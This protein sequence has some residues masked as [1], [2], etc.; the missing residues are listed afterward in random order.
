MHYQ[1]TTK[2]SLLY[3]VIWI[4]GSKASS[5]HWETGALDITQHSQPA[6]SHVPEYGTLE[7]ILSMITMI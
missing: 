4:T 2:M 3:T 1:G 5:L 7:Q 6:I